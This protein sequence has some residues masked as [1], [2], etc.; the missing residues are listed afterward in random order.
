MVMSESRDALVV[1][2]LSKSYAAVQAVD[3]VSFRVSRGEIFGLLGPNGAGKTT[4]IRIVLDII[5]PDAGQIEV[6]GGPMSEEK[7]SR[8]GYLPEERGLYDDM[9]LLDTLLFLGQLKGLSRPAAGS[10]AE[11]YLREVELWDVRDRKIEAL[12]RGMSQK[13]QFVA[14]TMHEPEL[15][16]VDE[17][18]A[19]LDPVNTQIIKGLLTRLRDRG[20]AIIMST[21]Q[22]NRVEEMCERILLI[23]HGRRVLYGAIREIRDRYATHAVEIDL[24]GPLPKI[25]GVSRTISSDGSHRLLLEAGVSPEDILRSLAEQTQLHIRRFE[26]VRASLEEIFL[27]VV[28]KDRGL[29]VEAA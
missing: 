22:M 11:R 24:D 2:N 18:F 16:I 27:Q 14:A 5:R 17:P 28:G 1:D 10:R 9:T 15:I 3:G 12:S 23:D 13:A 20:A 21:H 4:T 29:E 25:S 7:K 6:L 19:G 8:I 26:A